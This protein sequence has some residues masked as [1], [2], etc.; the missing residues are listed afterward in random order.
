MSRQRKIHPQV[1]YYEKSSKK[2]TT[3]M[4]KLLVNP[5]PAVPRIRA[6]KII[7]LVGAPKLPAQSITLWNWKQKVRGHNNFADPRKL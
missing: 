7:R 6:R 4:M 5:I 1:V 3:G 2:F